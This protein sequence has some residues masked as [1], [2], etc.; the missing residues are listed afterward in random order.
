M[1]QPEH[2]SETLLPLPKIAH[3]FGSSVYLRP[4]LAH[5]HEPSASIAED[6]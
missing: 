1:A 2:Y 5:T 3:T 6:T 4:D